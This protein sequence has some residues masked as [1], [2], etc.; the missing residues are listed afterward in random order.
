MIGKKQFNAEAIAKRTLFLFAI[1][2]ALILFLI[3]VF[4]FKEG[5]PIFNQ[6]NPVDFMLGGEWSPSKD[7]YG[8][9][10]FIA[11]TILITAGALMIAVPLGI[12]CSVFLAEIAP[13]WARELVRPA[14]ELLAGIP[15]IVYGLFALVV[16]VNTIE[17]SFDVPTGES[18]LAGSL[19]LAIMILPIIISIS[20]DSIEA[21]PRAYKEGS[22][23]MGATDTQTITRI[24]IPTATP[25]IVAGIILGMGRAIGETMAVVLVLGNVEKIPTNLLDQGEALTS[26]ILLEM[27][28]AAVGSPHYNALFALSMI[29]FMIVFSLSSIS[30]HIIAK[31]GLRPG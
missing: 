5:L 19:I 1:T 15:S 8:A 22:Y 11:A 28:E 13:K 12:S 16:I 25:G 27:G 9:L 18:I 10:P 4:I 17:V 7:V 29:L 6:I 3:V 24:V 31:R 14:I 23:A 26:V 21:V 2:G 20:Q 30:N